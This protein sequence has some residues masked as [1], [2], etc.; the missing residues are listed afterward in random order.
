MSAPIDAGKL[1]RRELLSLLARTPAAAAV[2][3]LV[4]GSAQAADIPIVEKPRLLQGPMLGAVGHDYALVWVRCANDAD[5]RVACST[6]PRFDDESFSAPVRADSGNEHA[7]VLRLDGLLP[8]TRYYYRVSVAGEQDPYLRQRDAQ[9]HSFTTAPAP[10]Q[11]AGFRLCFG[12]CARYAV[13]PVQSIW[14]VVDDYRPDLFCW[15]GDNVYVDS[16]NQQAFSDEYRRQREVA[17]LQPLLRRVPQLATWDDNDYGPNNGDGD[18]A[19]KTVALEKFNRYWAN[20]SH[21]LADTPGVFFRHSHGAVDLFFLDVRYHRS[22][23]ADADGPGKTMLGNDQL[24]WLQREL[25]ASGAV[26]K[27]ILSG[28]GWSKQKGA[29]GDAWS[30]F[31]HE[32]DALFDYI[33]DQRIEGVV[34]L[35]GDTHVG[36]LN[37]IPLSQQGGYDLYELVASPLAQ[38]P[39]KSWLEDAPEARIRQVCFDTPLFGVIDFDFQAADPVLR[40]NLVTAL[41]QLAW[42]WFEIPASSLRNGV[43]SW[44]A[45]M[46]PLSARRHANLE[47]Q[48]PYYAP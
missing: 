3:G 19:C 29:G 5:L 37:C 1:T 11:R 17:A 28:S 18:S 9:D 12:S 39:G 2:S 36:E 10:G 30:S 23:N 26:F 40:F 46:D 20:P 42:D 32:R 21:G 45:S 47:Q 14:N 34:L 33:R 15:L 35:S 48:R 24:A 16:V 4:A 22:P 25:K 41:G 43:S 44:R 8:D 6:E 7:V 27:L 31:L 38:G 13:D